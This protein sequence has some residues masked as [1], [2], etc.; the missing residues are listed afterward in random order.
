[1]DMEDHEDIVDDM[2]ESPQWNNGNAGILRPGRT[3][4]VTLTRT[5]ELFWVCPY[6]IIDEQQ[7]FDVFYAFLCMR[8]LYHGQHPEIGWIIVS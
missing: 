6:Y 7:A 8:S 3:L 4:N 5:E 2:L 1:M